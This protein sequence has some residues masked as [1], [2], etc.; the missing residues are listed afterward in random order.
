MG[1]WIEYAEWEMSMEE[2]N[3]ARSIFERAL[4]VDYQNVG[5]WL[6]YA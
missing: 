6:K 2:F 5:L 3:R 1:K 4:D